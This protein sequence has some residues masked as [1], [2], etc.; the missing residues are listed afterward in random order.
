MIIGT[1]VTGL[2][3]VLQFLNEYIT[4][5]LDRSQGTKHSCRVDK[6]DIIVKFLLYFYIFKS[7]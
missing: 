5:E 6:I 4:H 1:E 2:K 3:V 7:P